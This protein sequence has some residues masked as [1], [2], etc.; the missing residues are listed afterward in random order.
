MENSGP[1]LTQAYASLPTAEKNINQGLFQGV[2]E[3]GGKEAQ[4]VLKSAVQDADLLLPYRFQAAH[5]LLKQGATSDFYSA[6]QE[7]P[8]PELAGL[9]VAAAVAQDGPAAVKKVEAISASE[10]NPEKKNVMV[11]QMKI[12]SM[13]FQGEK[14]S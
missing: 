1:K 9:M 11:E 14:G 7:T 13:A 8:D 5:A 3:H 2:L 12:W 6:L 10:S 4:P